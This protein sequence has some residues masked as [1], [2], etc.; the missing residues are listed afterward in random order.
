MMI[1]VNEKVHT[2]FWERVSAGA[3]DAC[4]DWIGGK[5]PPGYG[6]LLIGGRGGKLYLA[7]RVS[8]TLAFG[9][10][11]KGEGFHGTVVRH[12]CDNV[13][14]VNPKHL[15]LGTQADNV[16]DSLVRNRYSRGSNHPGA[17][18]TENDVAEMRELMDWGFMQRVVAKAYGVSYMVCWNIRH[19]YKW[20]HVDSGT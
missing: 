20:R 13:S 4:W 14:C 16:K 6:T 17:K 12:S 9:S 18:L 11:P 8:Y 2:D 5:K 7:H 3:D 19:G 1:P 10:I 15:F